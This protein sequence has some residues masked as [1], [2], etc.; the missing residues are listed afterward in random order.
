MPQTSMSAD[1]AV[2]QNG[3][4]AYPIRTKVIDSKV[5]ASAAI[6]FGIFVTRAANGTVRAPALTGE[7]TASGVGFALRDDTK[8]FN[9]AG[10]AVGDQIPVL[11][12]G[13]IYAL[14]ETAWTEEGAVFARFTANGGNT[15]LGKI[16][17]D[18]DTANAVAIPNARFV[19]SGTAAGLAIVEV[20]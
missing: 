20:F 14:C 3:E 10:Y 11:R 15:V 12:K 7:V 2:A 4:L 5:A 13:Y 18:A 8:P 1:P 6:P 16:R 19:T 17:N 9:S